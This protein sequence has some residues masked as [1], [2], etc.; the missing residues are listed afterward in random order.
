MRDAFRRWR[1]RPALATTATVVLALGIGAT[2]AMFSI[3]DAVLLREEPWP[4]AGR[5]VRIYGVVRREEP[6]DR[7]TGRVVTLRA[8]RIGLGDRSLWLMFAGNGVGR[9]LH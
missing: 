4:D 3:V 9:R 8:D 6:I 5:L 7:R 1:R 2:T